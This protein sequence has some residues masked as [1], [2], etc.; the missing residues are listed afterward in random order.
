MR[1]SLPG[2]I[3]VVSV[4]LFAIW[5][6][7]EIP[8]T[9]LKFTTN[10]FTAVTTTPTKPAEKYKVTRVVDGDTIEIEGGKIIRYIGINTPETKDPRK[11]VECFGKE[12]ME[13]NKKL[14]DGKEVLLEEDVSNK[15]KYNRLLRYVWIDGKMINEQLVAD[16][17]AQVATYPPDVKYKDRF[18]G[19]QTNA[20]LK[21][22]GLWKK[23]K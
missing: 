21:L 16:G 17:Y 14:V 11:G 5:I 6:G 4:I 1:R 10:L 8:E 7:K 20:R 19:A 12:A 18:L 15:D 22:L 23:C 3:F 9:K 2:L 13:Y